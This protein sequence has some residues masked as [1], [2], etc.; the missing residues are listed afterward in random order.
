MSKC[1]TG[2][3][4]LYDIIALKY[5]QVAL[6]VWLRTATAWFPTRTAAVPGHVLV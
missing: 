4:Q 2:T 3:G 5:F 1:T 6:T